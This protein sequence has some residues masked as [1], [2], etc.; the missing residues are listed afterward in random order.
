ML[1]HEISELKI[2]RVV[3]SLQKM[4]MLSKIL[5]MENQTEIT[6]SDFRVPFINQFARRIGQDCKQIEQHLRKSGRLI[7]KVQSEDFYDEYAAQL[8]RVIDSLAGLPIE[9]IKDYADDLEQV[10]TIEKVEE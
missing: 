2:E 1:K 9:E 7:I 6:D 3:Y 4:A 5:L 10:I 8:W